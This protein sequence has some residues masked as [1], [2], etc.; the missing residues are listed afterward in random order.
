LLLGTGWFW[1]VFW[2]P[3]I[4]VSLMGMSIQESR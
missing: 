1:P 4:V 2:A 3:N